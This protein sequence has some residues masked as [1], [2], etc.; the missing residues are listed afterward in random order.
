MFNLAPISKQYLMLK[1]LYKPNNQI[2]KSFIRYF[3][4]V[5]HIKVESEIFYQNQDKNYQEILDIWNK[6]SESLTNYQKRCIWRSSNLGMKELDLAFGAWARSNIFNLS[7]AE[8]E[9]YEREILVEES[10]VLWKWI[11]EDPETTGLNE[12]AADH[13]IHTVRKFLDNKNWNHP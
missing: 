13:Y 7:E 4:S 6:K 5:D 2:T 3:T 8:C 10:P 12:F 9:R 1:N 11:L